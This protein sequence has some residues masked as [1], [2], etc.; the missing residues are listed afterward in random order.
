MKTKPIV[1]PCCGGKI[2]VNIQGRDNVFCSYCGTQIYLDQEKREHTINRNTN[3]NVNINKTF[4]HTE[5]HIDQAEVLRCKNEDNSEKRAV[6]VM[7]WAFGS[8]LVMI[9]ALVLFFSIRGSISK[10]QGK[11]SA[12]DYN[13]LIGQHY[14][15]VVAHFEAAGFTNIEV[16]DLN[17]AGIAIWN[18]EKVASISIGGD[19]SFES[20]DWFYPDTKVVITYH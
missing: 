18:E 16:I 4:T 17:D 8:V 11:I 14:K 10:A 3:K 13:D 1:C 2:D 5:V 9:L 7:A 12:G 19:T 15:S 20:V 6:R